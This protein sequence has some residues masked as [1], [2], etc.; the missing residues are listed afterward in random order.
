MK[1][2]FQ[3]DSSFLIAEKLK[4]LLKSSNVLSERELDGSASQDLDVYW[5]PAMAEILE[6]WGIGNVWNEIQFL[7]AN[8]SGKVLD[9]ACG[10]G[11]TMALLAK[12]TQ[13]DVYGFDISDLLISK[14]LERGI[15]ADHLLVEDATNMTYGD[16]SFDYAYSIGSLEHFT[17][18]GILKFISECQRVV[19]VSS[20][21]QIP[22]SRSGKNEGWIKTNQSYHNNS[23]E[24][25]L[26][27]FEHTFQTVYV[28][29]SAWEDKRSVGKWFI[30][31]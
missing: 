17:E 26:E 6:T 3:K 10:T 24:W 21:H 29:D 15:A 11:K 18:D 14:A 13:I 7:M 23:S 5:D 2:I 30:C 22:V 12:F 4:R 9:I 31:K 20:M 25:W 1:N 19:R 8:C 27:K 28:L 16:N